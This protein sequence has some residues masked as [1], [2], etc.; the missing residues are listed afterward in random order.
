MMDKEK[1]KEEEKLF[2]GKYFAFTRGYFDQDLVLYNFDDTND[3]EVNFKNCLFQIVPKGE[4]MFK[5]KLIKLNE[6]LLNITSIKELNEFNFSEQKSLY[7]KYKR[8]IQNNHY[9]YNQLL[10]T[11]KIIDSE[12][13]VQL[14]HLSTGKFVMYKEDPV[15]LKTYLTLTNENSKRTNFRIKLGFNYQSE[16]STKVYSN[17]SICLV[18]GDNPNGKQIYISYPVSNFNDLGNNDNASPKPK[19]FLNSNIDNYNIDQILNVEVQPEIDFNNAIYNNDI[20]Q[21]QSLQKTIKELSEN[22]FSIE[23]L[24]SKDKMIIRKLRVDRKK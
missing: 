21:N 18:C 15:S 20:V 8:E 1:K 4:Y 22:S 14:I 13:C 2:M 3:I 11:R 10:S 17:T 5:K 19:P 16:N 7:I 6:K 23:N 12:D 9:L 24:D